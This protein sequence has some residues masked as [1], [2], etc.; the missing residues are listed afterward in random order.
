M[1]TSAMHFFT[2]KKIDYFNLLLDSFLENITPKIYQM[3]MMTVVSVDGILW[4]I[5]KTEMFTIAGT[6]VQCYGT[7]DWKLFWTA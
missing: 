6:S 7:Q 5:I 1:S 2:S 4:C 3:M